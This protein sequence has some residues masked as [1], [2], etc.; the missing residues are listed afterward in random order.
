MGNVDF[1]ANI[2]D[3]LVSWSD[4]PYAPLILFVV[5]LID[6]AAVFLP[7]EPLLIAMAIAHPN[8]AVLYAAIAIVSSVLGATITY[9]VGRL[10]GRPLAERF[11]SRERIETAED[12][13]Q[14]HGAI[15]LGITAFT[16]VP[17]PPFVLAAGISHL[18]VWRFV[19]ASLVGRGA[20]FFGMGLAIFFFGSEIQRFL[21]QYLGWATLIVGVLIVVAYVASRYFSS[22][23]EK[24]ARKKEN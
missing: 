11:V 19:V 6:S 8:L 23:F 21:E 20:R 2:V 9:Y 4:S 3:W 13:F 7:P 5:S 22:R 15:T 12:F 24:Q 14:N 18:G 16:P 1:L 17:Y 10:G